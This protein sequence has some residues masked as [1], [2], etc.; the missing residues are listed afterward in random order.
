MI[1]CLAQRTVLLSYP[2]IHLRVARRNGAFG[3]TV[4]AV[5]LMGEVIQL[6]ADQATE[7][8]SHE[9]V[10]E[11][12]DTVPVDARAAPNMSIGSTI[13]T[14]KHTRCAASSS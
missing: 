1:A 13:A 11:H 5:I 4:D 8:G 14:Q 10:L 2:L 6:C 12:T 3:Y 7:E 9:E